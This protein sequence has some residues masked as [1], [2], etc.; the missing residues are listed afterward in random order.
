M[1]FRG[2]SNWG[3]NR[4]MVSYDMWHML[5]S[6]SETIRLTAIPEDLKVLCNCSDYSSAVATWGPHQ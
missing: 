5:Y 4:K 2:T 6:N 1:D 3:Q